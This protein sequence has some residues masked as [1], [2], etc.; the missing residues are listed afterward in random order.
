VAADTDE[1]D[2]AVGPLIAEGLRLLKA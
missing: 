2:K 1:V